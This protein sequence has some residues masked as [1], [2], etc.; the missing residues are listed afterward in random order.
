MWPCLMK[1]IVTTV[2][3]ADAFWMAKET[4]VAGN[5]AATTIFCSSKG[6]STMPP[7]MGLLLSIT[8]WPG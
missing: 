4:V 2:S 5:A 8:V 6:V 1:V 7:M 3:P